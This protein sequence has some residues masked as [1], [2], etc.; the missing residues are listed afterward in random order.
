KNGVYATFMPKPLNGV[1][2]SGM[3]VHQSLFKN[4]KNM[5]FDKKDK[6]FLSSDAK[7]YIAGI[8][9]HVK[10]I[11]LVTNQWINSYKRLVPGYEAPVY[12]A[13][14]RRNR[15]VLVRV[16]QVKL[17]KEKSTRIEARFPDPGAN[18]YLAFSVMLRAG[19]EGIKNKIPLKEPVEADVYEMDA[20]E[21]RANKIDILPGSLLE[22]L[23]E[24]QESALV[25]ETLGSHVFEK[26]IENKK[27]E[28]DMY[29]IKVSDY[30]IER[31]FS[32]L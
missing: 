3:H 10:E 31:Y 14:A 1:N 11:C 13:W 2:G 9:K 6:Y 17:G 8:M 21:R 16:P 32:I 25:K 22:A 4:G 27:I 18:P 29:R 12:I 23:E 20:I 19:L 30:E 5:F 15:S 28:W 7:H 26:L 24:T